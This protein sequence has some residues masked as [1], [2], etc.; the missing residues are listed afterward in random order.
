M[1]LR[2]LT[3]FSLSLLL[4]PA[5]NAQSVLTPSP[6]RTG[7]RDSTGAVLGAEW[8]SYNVTNSFET[9]YRFTTVG[10]DI[11][12]FRS[13]E[14][15]GNGLRLFG[16]SFT[17]NS[18]DGHG[19]LF[20]ALSLTTSGLGNDPYGMANVRIEKNGL[21]RYDMT[22][23][24]NDYYNPALLNGE[25][26]TLKRTH[27]TVQD[28]DLTVTLS[29]WAQAKLGYTRN[30]ETGPEYSAYELYIGG[31]ARDVLPI[32][33]DARRDWNEYRLGTQLDFYGFRL[34][35]QHQWEYFKDDSSYAS[36]IPGEPYA[37]A[38]LLNQPYQPSLAVTYPTLATAYSRSAPMHIRTPGWF[39]NLNRS[40]RLWAMNAKL[41]Y[42]KADQTSD[43][44][45]TESGASA[46]ANSAC[47]N[48]GIGRPGTASTFSLGT[49]REPFTAGD[50]T[51][52]LFV[53]SKLTVSNSVSAQDY[54]YDGIAQ[55]LQ[56]STVAAPK[57]VL[58]N[59]RMGEGRVSD[60]LDA[61]YEVTKKLFLN[62]EYRYTDRWVNY[63]LFRSGTTNNQDFNSLSNHM[64]TGTVGV[65]VKP[66]QGLSMNVD[67][68]V[69]R[70]NSALTPV[71]MAHFHN[72]K[73]RVQYQRKRFLVAATYRQLYNLNAP[74]PV[75]FT[76]AYGPPPLS[77]FASHSRD[78][79]FTSSFQI[80]R[81]LS[82]DTTYSH[83]RL[84]TFANLW[85]ELPVNANTIVSVPGYVATYVSNIHTF[86]T[87]LR[88]SFKDRVTL[89]A[90]YT[91]T[92]DTGDGRRVQN[93]GL[94]DPAASFLAAASTFPMFYQAPLARISIRLSPRIQW[95]V[96]WEFYFYN[97]MFAYFGYQPY[98]RA[99]TGYASLSL[100]L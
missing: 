15:Y 93:V 53:T 58:W 49:A 69:G 54:S 32:D 22:W 25:S 81:V 12:L 86:S 18:K 17:A 99:Q 31:L 64:H 88:T 62:A 79:S 51:L 90:G 46:V 26:D 66:V 11:G 2:L 21:Y 3:L 34:T 76:S 19:R 78:F 35:L 5:L 56:P 52:S 63:E 45:E 27:R 57:N 95:N 13:V 96:G 87:T 20:D 75:V 42:S 89:Y 36:L 48:C 40:T 55:I 70:D 61:N 83:M 100:T 77:Y 98:Y 7:A 9:G 94:T 50:L 30:H 91:I 38:S 85:I 84:D 43:Y 28:H 29:K 41:T 47:S 14:N 92:R 8:G 1:Y 60:S 16:G 67:A 37:L 24:R 39:A 73:G 82:V 71:A 4:L 72:F 59:R 44:I 68:T 80:S 97:Q 23:R 33:R 10:G 65:R 74:R 6:D